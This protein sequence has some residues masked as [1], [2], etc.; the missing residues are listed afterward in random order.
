MTDDL[1][2]GPTLKEITGDISKGANK[3]RNNRD[4]MHKSAEVWAMKRDRIQKQ[5]REKR[6]MANAVKKQRDAY[7]L[8]SGGK[9]NYT[10]GA[11][12]AQEKLNKIYEEID[13]L[14]KTAEEA[15]QN[16]VLCK[17]AADIEHKK[18]VEA[19]QKIRETRDDLSD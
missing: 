6:D 9:Y 4:D 10:G 14:N 16:F 7:R 17:E 11:G 2:P 15:H 12:A 8:E 13:A 5:I 18:F 1:P 3:H 19:L